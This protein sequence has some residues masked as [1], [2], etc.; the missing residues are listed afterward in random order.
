MVLAYVRRLLDDDRDEEE[1]EREREKETMTVVP[2]RHGMVLV[3]AVPPSHRLPPPVPCAGVG[4][5]WTTRSTLLEKH[6]RGGVRGPRNKD[7]STGTAAK[8]NA[9]PRTRPLDMPTGGRVPSTGVGAWWS[10]WDPSSRR[11]K[12]HISRWRCSF[13]HIT[14]YGTPFSWDRL[15]V[16]GR[17]GSSPGFDDDVDR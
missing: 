10:N 11:R 9:A 8:G 17:I 15:D 13:A 16:S 5:G 6:T 12:R 7:R 2:R 1:R 3:S 4:K 14:S